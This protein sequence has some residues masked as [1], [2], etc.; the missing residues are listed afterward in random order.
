MCTLSGHMNS[1]KIGGGM[2]RSYH[3]GALAE[4]MV[5]QALTEVRLRGA[6][7]V[8]LRGVAHSVDVSPSAAYNHFAQKDDLLRA[9]GAFGLAALD[10][11]MARVLAAHP[12]QT[13]EAARARFVGLGRAYLAFALDET[14][15][16][17]LTFGPIC[18]SKHVPPEAAGPYRKL[19]AA[20]DDLDEWELLK[21][22]IRPGLDV[23]VWAATHGM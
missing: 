23:M 10:E 21:P 12:A 6:D 8:S 17:Q 3:H 13:A 9:V 14:H 5:E 15:L 16:F 20:L 4:A 11:R 7:Q 22:G 19:V 18:A 1:V 2:A